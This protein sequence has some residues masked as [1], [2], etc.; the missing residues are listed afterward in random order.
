MRS[1]KHK[2]RLPKPFLRS[3]ERHCQKR[4]GE[5]CGLPRLPL[6]MIF[7]GALAAVSIAAQPAYQ[8]IA[9]AP[10]AHPAMRS[11]AEILARKIGL[12]PERVVMERGSLPRRGDIVLTVA[13]D[14][15]PEQSKLLGPK[16]KSLKYDGYIILFRDGGALICGARPRSLL[17]AAG[18]W[19]LWKEVS[20]GSFVRE[21]SFAIRTGQYDENRSVAEYVAELGVNI[22]IGKP[23]DYVVT[24]E[25]TLP[26]VYARLDQRE[27]A[28]LAATKAERMRKNLA[29]A[30]ECHDADVDFYAFLFGS[31][32][33]RWSPALYEAALRVYPT[34]KGVAAPASFEKASLCPSDPA[35][36]KLIRAYIQDLS[37]QTGADGLYVTFW[38]HYG[39]Y[40]QDER[41]RRNGLNRFPDELYEA[42][43][44]Y[45]EA[46]RP[47]R[48]RLVVRTWSSGTPHWLR[49]EF[50]HAPGYGHFGGTGVDLWGRVIR[51][52]PPD[53]IL[54]TKVYNADCQPDAP[55]SP[56]IG[57]AK[58]H[59]EIAEYQVSGQTVGRFYFPASTVDYMARTMRRAHDLVS[60][61]GGVNI[62]PGGT[63]QSNYSV[64]DDILN[65]INLYAWRELSWDVEVDLEK[66]WK[67]WA[68]PIYGA[69]AAPHIVRALRR[70]EEAVY[71]TFSTLGMGTET[72]SSF[73][74][75]IERRET[76][77]KYTN[78]YYLPEYARFLEPTEE[79]ITRVVEEKEANLRRIAEMFAEI[80]RARPYLRDEQYDEL[81]TRFTWLKEYAICARYLDESLWRYRYLRYLASMLT[82]DPK[83]LKYLAIAYDA[84]REHEKLL[85]RYD[86]NQKFSCYNTILGQLRV[87]PSLGSPLPLMRELY[88]KSKQLIENVVGPDYLPAERRR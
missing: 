26:E 64:F 82:T 44:R 70:S 49:G 30:K 75:T 9:F 79:N 87:K 14:L 80:A 58:P 53:I 40:C 16:A 83:Q 63:R 4:W 25:E 59:V 23:N 77:L 8:R 46:L 50:V 51:E 39:L 29:F 37:A 55:F 42:V 41:C 28:R 5:G 43:K 38:D 85:F 27:R 57:Q 81:K 60:S 78:R 71:R 62:F 45:D 54:Q 17:Y 76:L 3:W 72:N 12:S 66:V 19:R 48:K 21:P 2:E 6:W 10:G 33:A 47:L 88:E 24:L 7:W 52:T 68:K 20:S 74:E 73:A 34:I 32:F 56:L 86:P 35:T 61:D 13:P 31:D 18:D 69:R 84:V 1:A 22:I 11:A 65:S 15:L 36:W 67:D